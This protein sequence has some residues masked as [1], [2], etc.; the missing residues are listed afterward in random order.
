MTLHQLTDTL[1]S[2]DQ[3]LVNLKKQHQNLRTLAD[4]IQVKFDTEAIKNQDLD[5]QLK[6]M[7]RQLNIE[8]QNAL[9]SKREMNEY[10]IRNSQL[11]DEIYHL[12]HER[13]CQ[14]DQINSL[15][16]RVRLF[17]LELFSFN[18][19]MIFKLIN[20][21]NVTT[22][23]QI[24]IR[25]LECRVAEIDRLKTIEDLIQS[26]RWD[27]ITKLAQTMQTVSRTMAQATSPTIQRKKR[28]ELQ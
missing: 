26:Q 3:E 2:K 19:L 7:Q 14:T 22:N 27:D 21:E 25:G 15:Q 13:D 6:Q 5:G 24:E 12:Q 23:L 8:I 20:E 11:R 10:E 9:I 18:L 4:N 1:Q 28:V 17:Y 16:Q